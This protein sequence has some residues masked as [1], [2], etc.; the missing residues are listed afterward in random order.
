MAEPKVRLSMV[1]PGT[2]ML[3]SQD[4]EEMSKDEAYTKHSLNL[5]YEVQK[6]KKKSRVKETIY[7]N[8]RNCVPARHNISLSKEAYDSMT[9]VLEIPDT[10]LKKVWG[11]YSKNKRL[12]YH[13]SKIAEYFNALSFT[14]EVF[15]E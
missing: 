5:E 6:G 2:T 9:N 1:V 7:F 15:D 3:S 10:K 8:T 14:Y 12:E 13:L 4:C 11:M